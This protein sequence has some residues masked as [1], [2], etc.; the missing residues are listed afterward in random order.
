MS[1]EP[2][3]TKTFFKETVYINAKFKKGKF[4]LKRNDY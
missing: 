2:K 4:L 1:P 3:K